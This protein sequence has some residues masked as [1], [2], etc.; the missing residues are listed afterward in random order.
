MGSAPEIIIVGVETHVVPAE[1]ASAGLLDAVGKL[2]KLRQ[3]SVPEIAEPKP[4]R[5]K[6]CGQPLDKDAK[7]CPTCG[8]KATP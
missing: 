7:T 3:L 6:E 8:K 2:S 4:S 5:C 1:S